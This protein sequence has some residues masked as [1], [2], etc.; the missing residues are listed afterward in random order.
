ME[1]KL[2][3]ST[4]ALIDANEASTWYDNQAQ[5]LGPRFLIDLEKTLSVIQR[6]PYTFSFLHGQTRKARLAKF[7]FVVL[8]HISGSDVYI[9]G[10]VSTKRSNRYM[11]KRGKRRK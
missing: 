1:Y 3:Y 4:L 9:A 5:G 6:N 8:Y 10:V 7:P 2:V 11:R